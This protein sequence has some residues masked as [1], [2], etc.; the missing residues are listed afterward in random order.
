MSEDKQPVMSREEIAAVIG[1]TPFAIWV[2]ASLDTYRHGEVEISIPMRRELTQHHG[3]GH[4]AIIG[5]LA[6]SACAWA[7]ASVAGDVVTSEYK[8]NMFAP[9]VGQTLVGHG[10]VLHYGGRHAVCRADVYALAGS[11]KKL[12]ATALATIFQVKP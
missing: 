4:G 12:V 8:L 10:Q 3:F 11:R 5:F 1:K 6:D 7:A 9:A 2:G